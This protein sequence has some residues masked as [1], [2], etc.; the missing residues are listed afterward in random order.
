MANRFVTI[1]DDVFNWFKKVFSN[2]PAETTRALT[3][4][5]TLAPEAE[6]VFALVDSKDAAAFNPIINEATA[7]LGTVA[8]MLKQGQTNGIDGFLT[9]IGANLKTLITDGH[10]K[11]TDSVQKATGI[12]NG[13]IA[14]I[15][16]I[17]A[18]LNL[19]GGQTAPPAA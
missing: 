3:I 19:G 1:A 2:V 6:M 16:S 17:R 12:V 11:N 18:L 4:V 5:N 13:V 8:N 7:D 15:N 9:S 10:I 14:G